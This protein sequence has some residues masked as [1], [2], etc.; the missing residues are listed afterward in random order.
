MPAMGNGMYTTIQDSSILGPSMNFAK[1]ALHFTQHKDSEF[2]A[3]SPNNDYSPFDPVI[4]FA[5][6]IDG[7]ASFSTFSP[8][9]FPVFPF[10]LCISQPLSS[11]AR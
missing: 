2:G 4:D 11:P 1:Q 8:S 7:C 10:F 9:P 6:Y 5:K 3:T